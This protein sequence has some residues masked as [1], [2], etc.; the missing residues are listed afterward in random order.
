L[1]LP[2]FPFR[3]TTVN[4]SD[5]DGGPFLGG[6]YF[7]ADPE[8]VDPMYSNYDLTGC[9]P[10]KDAGSNALLPPDVA[11][12]DWDGNTTEPIPLDIDLT[13]RKVGGGIPAKTDIGAFE[14]PA[15]CLE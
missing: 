11:D 12:L 13:P 15:Q 8:F 1:I 2:H 5:V 3:P 9:S 10:C 14:G 4:Y 7:Y 6:N